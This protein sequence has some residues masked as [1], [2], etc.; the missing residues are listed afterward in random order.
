MLDRPSIALL[1]EWP[2]NRKLNQQDFPFDTT[3]KLG[4]GQL[5]QGLWRCGKSTASVSAHAAASRIS[6]RDLELKLHAFQTLNRSFGYTVQRAA[7][8]V[9]D[10]AL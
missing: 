10:S 3:D 8:E 9:S 1:D 5:Q 2:A 4:Q 7:G 6:A